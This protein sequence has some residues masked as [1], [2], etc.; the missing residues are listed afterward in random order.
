MDRPIQ[1]KKITPRRIAMAAG[2][3]F[4]IILII[5]GLKTAGSGSILRVD[6]EKLI[7]SEITYDKFLEFIPVQGTIMPIKTFY[8]DALQGG[9]VV[10]TFLEEGI[11]VEIGD[12]IL[13]LDN[14]DLHLDIMYREAQLIEQINNLRNTRLA[15]E[16][17]S[18][19]LRGDLLDIDRMI[20][21]SQRDYNTSVKLKEKNLISDEEFEQNR[22]DFEYWKER[23]VL[24]LETQRQ[25]SILREIQIS[26]LE[27]SVSRMQ[28]NM[29]I[30]RKKLENLIVRAPIAGHLTS[31]NA[32]VGESKARGERLGQIDVLE[33]FKIRAEIDEYY[34]ARISVGQKGEVKIA[35]DDYY[36]VATKVYPEV[37]NGRFFVDM[38][39]TGDPPENIRR[40]QT[41]QVKLALGDLSEAILLPRGGFFNETGGNWIFVVDKSGD[42]AVRREIRLGRMN[43][44][45]YEVLEGLEPGERAVTSSY[46]NFKDFDRLVLKNE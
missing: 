29:E 28:S 7:I 20:R 39:F 1:K 34:I 38:E 31:L 5:L 42:F 12:S 41:A 37:R 46:A 9:T 24:T 13:R 32:E 4:I 14:T 16:Q 36:L 22:N 43:P 18:L 26:Q 27:E 21:N 35:G 8:L 3:L 2:G 33:G 6:S 25:D 40:G 19:R 15:M 10:E 23:K 44:Q 11:L 45:V 30:V 17:N